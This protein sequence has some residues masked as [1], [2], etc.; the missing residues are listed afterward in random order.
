VKPPR[1]DVL[2]PTDAEAIALARNLLR[3]ASHGALATLD[4]ETGA[5]LAS[6]VAVATDADGAPLIL[7]SM[8]AAHTGAL[9][10]D[11]R[12]ALLVGEPGRGDPLAH[13]RLSVNCRA[14]R[15][16]RDTPDGM[17][18]ER[19]YLNHNEK[20]KLYAGFADFHYF[21]LEPEGALLNGGFGRAYALER[22]DLLVEAMLARLLGDAE[23]AMLERINA[24]HAEELASL[25][26]RHAKSGRS[27]WRMTGI[28]ADGCDLAGDGERRRIA[29][30][31]PVRRLAELETRLAE[32]IGARRQSG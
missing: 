11:P 28:D 15:L 27:G 4:P 21:R 22:T 9:L 20:A 14:A 3:T 12:C 17:R 6:R 13:P 2:R 31:V 19:R 26:R 23:Q 29:F 18:A 7:A 10:V 30:S 16:D 1:A 8:L 25:A 5:P 32:L 24:D